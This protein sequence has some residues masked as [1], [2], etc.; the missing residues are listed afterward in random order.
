MAVKLVDASLIEKTILHLVVVY[1]S[2]NR[3]RFAM[4]KKNNSSIVGASPPSICHPP[5]S[6]QSVVPPP[7]PLSLRGMPPQLGAWWLA[8]GMPMPAG[9]KQEKACF[10]FYSNTACFPALD[11]M[12]YLNSFFF[13]YRSLYCLIFQR[14]LNH[15]WSTA[16][17][18]HELL[19]AFYWVTPKVCRKCVELS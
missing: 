8:W 4:A 17:I 13:K 9:C 2:S 1:A 18:G 5:W 15:S 12:T 3:D 19:P 14:V 11:L 16:K 6:L 7:R 10:W